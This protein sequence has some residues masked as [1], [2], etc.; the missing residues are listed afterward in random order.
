M[1]SP[2][3]QG[4]DRVPTKHLNLLL[5]QD[6]CSK[7][8][9]KNNKNPLTVDHWYKLK[10]FLLNH[11]KLLTHFSPPFRYFIYPKK[12][13]INF[14]ELPSFGPKYRSKH[15]LIRS[16][17]LEGETEIFSIPIVAH[18]AVE[19]RSRS[20]RTNLQLVSCGGVDLL[21]KKNIPK[22]INDVFF[23]MF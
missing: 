4:N 17:L 14:Q 5:H 11:P 2:S 12:P 9:N 15:G 16:H 22:E 23:H 10:A 18:S 7:A 13:L 6:I 20:C 1:E 8:K 21:N 3:V 19:V